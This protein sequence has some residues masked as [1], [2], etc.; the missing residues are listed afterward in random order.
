DTPI[1]YTIPAGIGCDTLV[2]VFLHYAPQPTAT[3]TITFCPG[4]SVTID[5]TS[6]G[7]PG[8]VSGMIAATTGCDTLATYTLQFAPQ[9]TFSQTIEFCAGDTVILGGLA[10]T[11]PGTVNLVLAA[12]IGCDTLATYTLQHLVPSQPTA[13][14]LSCPADRY[15]DADP[16]QLSVPVVYDQPSATSNCPC[17]GVQLSLQSGLVSGSNFPLGATDVCYN[18]KDSCGNS[19]TCCFKVTVENKPACDVKVI[20]CIKYELL[21]ITQDAQQRKTYRIRTTNNCANRMTYLAIQIPDG[22]MADQP[23]NNATYTAPG[24]RTYLVRNPNFSP[25]Y[26]LRYSSL[27]DSIQNGEAD[28]F[29]YTLPPQAD[30]DYI[31]VTVK[32]ESGVYYEAH[33]NTF[34]CPIEYE[35]NNR[36]G[37]QRNNGQSSLTLFPNPTTGDLFVDLAD[38]RGQKVQ[39]RVFNAAGSVV[40]A[41][42]VLVNEP[43]Q[44][45]EL[46]ASLANGLYLLEVTSADGGKQAH[47][48]VV[49]R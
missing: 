43:V 17:P 3:K 22:L 47:R 35:P 18:A 23:V 4:D 20:S 21:S 8:M 26:S 46:P 45:V 1:S 11:Q 28:V 44:P 25:F 41:A 42:Q 15:V 38:W 32:L 12:A 36:P 5:G 13:I 30:L 14:T 27:S 31:H 9:P 7:Q 19:V 37:P 16:G 6:Y 39:L 33:L 48:F 29:Q 10:Y 2:E 40:Q 24:G 34:F 49:Q